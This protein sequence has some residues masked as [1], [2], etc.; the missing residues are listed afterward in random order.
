MRGNK[1][2][3]LLNGLKC[4]KILT[5]NNSGIKYHEWTFLNFARIELAVFLG[6]FFAVRFWTSLT[7]ALSLQPHCQPSQHSSNEIHFAK[8]YREDIEHDF[9]QK[10]NGVHRCF[11]GNLC[12][13]ILLC[14][15]RRILNLG[16]KALSR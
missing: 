15:N 7:R 16:C 9:N 2:R 4:L 11:S 6:V 3:I 8:I 14:S 12:T 10:S 13:A 1:S 5:N